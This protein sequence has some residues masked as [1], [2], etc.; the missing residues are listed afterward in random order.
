[1]EMLV[2]EAGL[3]VV[4]VRRLDPG[5]TVLRALLRGGVAHIDG[6]LVRRGLAPRYLFSEG[7]SIPLIHFTFR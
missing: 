7:S 5:R 1:M 4:F 2:E 6:V 3:V